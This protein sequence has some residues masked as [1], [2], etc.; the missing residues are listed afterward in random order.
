MPGKKIGKYQLGDTLGEGNYGKVKLAQHIETG[1]RF[2]VKI[3]QKSKL[4]EEGLEEQ[5]KREITVQ[6]MLIHK[7]VV[8]LFEVMQTDNNIYLVLELITGGELFDRII[9]K[10]RFD[11]D[12]ARRYFQELSV[13]LYYCHQQGVA[14]RDLKPENLLLDDHD[15][16]KITDFGLSNYQKAPEGS[17]QEG[18]GGGGALLQTVC[19]TPNYVAPEVLKTDDTGEGYNGFTADVWTCGVILFVMVAGYLPFDE[20][21]GNLNALF[22]II[23][24]GEYRFPRNPAFSPELQDLIRHILVTDPKKRYSLEDIM[25]HKWFAKD[26]DASQVEAFRGVSKVQPTAEQVKNWATRAEETGEKEP[27]KA[28]KGGYNAFQLVDKVTGHTLQALLSQDYTMADGPAPSR[29]AATCHMLK[30][31]GQDAIAAVTNVMKELGAGPQPTKAD[32]LV[33]KGAITQRGVLTFASTICPTVSQ[34][35]TLLSIRKTKGETLR[36]HKTHDELISKLGDLVIP[37]EPLGAPAE[38]SPA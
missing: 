10:K 6:K 22:T 35:L 5:M 7:H 31:N 17:A 38:P 18:G 37:G 20:Q 27:K 23:Q 19:G 26:F 13:G 21:S 8:R 34:R 3:V 16:I 25:R 30:C 4:R 12:T 9:Q 15:H 28:Q 32:P 33:I 36:Y 14:H 1:Q 29:R 2:A 11:E 24:R